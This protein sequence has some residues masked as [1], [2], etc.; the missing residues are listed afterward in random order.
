MAGGI[1]TD[2]PFEFNV[3]CAIISVI[4]IILFLLPGNTLYKDGSYVLM[5]I[6]SLLFIILYV[7]VAYYDHLYNCDTIMKS[8]KYS[9]TRS[10][11]P[12]EQIGLQEEHRY[13]KSI[14]LMHVVIISPL[15]ILIASRGISLLN[16]GDQPI[17][18]YLS[19]SDKYLFPTVGGLGVLTLLYHGI[20]FNYPRIP[21]DSSVKN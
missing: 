14:H 11:K 9:I 1:F 10:F 3:K 5:L 17:D 16:P 4:G 15:L 13:L 8:G 20:R 7:A 2:K 6:I 12:H 18:K 19:K 21:A